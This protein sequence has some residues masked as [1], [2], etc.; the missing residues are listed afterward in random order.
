M[1][2]PTTMMSHGSASV[3]RLTH[4]NRHSPDARSSLGQDSPA[5]AWVTIEFG[6]RCRG[7]L[8]FGMGRWR[9]PIASWWSGALQALQIRR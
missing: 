8:T 1:Q 7:A 3:E 9:V 4:N 2:Q 5:E 6:R